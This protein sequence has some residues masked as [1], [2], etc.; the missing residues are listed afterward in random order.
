[1]PFLFAQNIKACEIDIKTANDEPL[2]VGQEKIIIIT[3]NLTHRNCSIT[4]EETKIETDGIKIL[5]ATKWKE[6]APGKL[7][8]KLKVE[9]EKPGEV[10]I[11]VTRSC[12]KEG[13]KGKLVL[14]AIQ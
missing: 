7:E 1:M 4:P 3:V 11:K 8:R 2:K 9:A 12:K 14:T 13:G 6:S 10:S 5:A